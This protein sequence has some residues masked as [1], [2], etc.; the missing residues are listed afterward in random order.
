MQALVPEQRVVGF[1]VPNT[2]SGE[3]SVPITASPSHPSQTDRTQS[4]DPAPTYQPPID[5]VE[6][7]SDSIFRGL[8]IDSDYKARSMR[9]SKRPAT[10]VET[11]PKEKA[12]VVGSIVSATITE[13][14]TR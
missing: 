14:D 6:P 8:Y 13:Y 7:V 1:N 3:D 10:K 5:H 2:S 11:V 4:M 12:A 9:K